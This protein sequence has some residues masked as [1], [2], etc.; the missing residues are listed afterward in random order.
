[1]PSSDKPRRVHLEPCWWCKG[2]G[3]LPVTLIK[4]VHYTGPC[5]RCDGTGKL[6]ALVEPPL[7]GE[8]L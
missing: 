2:T 5:P 8:R 6:P 3:W 1:M 7:P 4:G